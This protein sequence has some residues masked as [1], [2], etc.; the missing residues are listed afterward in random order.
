MNEIS[1]ENA[2]FIHSI[3]MKRRACTLLNRN[4]KGITGLGIRDFVLGF[5]ISFNIKKGCMGTKGKSGVYFYL[6][7]P[8]LLTFHLPSCLPLMLRSTIPKPY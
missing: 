2:C 7:L 8:F 5:Y 4:G 1:E 6:I 3:S